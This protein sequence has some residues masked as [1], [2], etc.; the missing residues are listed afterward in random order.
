MN[1]TI[2]HAVAIW[3]DDGNMPLIVSRTLTPA[4]FR[5]RNT[6]C[7]SEL[8]LTDPNDVRAYLQDFAQMNEPPNEFVMFQSET[9]TTRLSR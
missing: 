2:V 3:F 4:S 8:N 6:V 1:T 7:N 5:F 9:K